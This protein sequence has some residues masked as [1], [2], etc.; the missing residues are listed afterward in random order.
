MATPF[1]DAL[2]PGQRAQVAAKSRGTNRPTYYDSTLALSQDRLRSLGA[3]TPEANALDPNV[4]ISEDLE[5]L[6]ILMPIEDKKALLQFIAA[7]IGVAGSLS[8]TDFALMTETLLVRKAA[9]QQVYTDVGSRV[10][11]YDAT[12][13]RVLGFV[14]NIAR[15]QTL[16]DPKSDPTSIVIPELGTLFSSL[17]D[18]YRTLS[19]PDTLAVHDRIADAGVVFTY[20][21]AATNR[22]KELSSW[23]NVINL[24][25]I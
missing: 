25:L 24:Y 15:Q 7:A 19:M 2:T 13:A 18:S 11:Q 8:N 4:Q 12:R 23:I 17:A 3:E 16:P 1:I 14:E 9:Y 5:A 20:Q 22:T 6:L 21:N 10:L